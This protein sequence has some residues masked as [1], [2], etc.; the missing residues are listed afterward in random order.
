MTTTTGPSV[1]GVH[2]SPRA[3]AIVRLTKIAMG[4]ARGR[5]FTTVMPVRACSLSSNSTWCNINLNAAAIRWMS[6]HSWGSMG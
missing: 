1:R 3:A 5:S 6:L 2:L 4:R